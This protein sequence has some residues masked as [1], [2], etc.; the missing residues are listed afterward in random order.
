VPPSS[1]KGFA[2]LSQA[3]SRTARPIERHL[4]I[5]AVLVLAL[6][7]RLWRL[8]RNGYGTEYYAAGV[9]SMLE[10]WH[11]FL[12]NAFDPAGFV[13]VDKPPVALWIQAASARLLG[14]SGFS[15]ILPQVLEGVGSILILYHLVRRRFGDRAGLLAALFLAMTPISV[16]VDRTNNTDGCLVFVLLLSGWAMSLAVERGSGRWLAAALTLVGVGFNVKMLA[17]CVVLPGFAAV[18]LYGAPITLGRRILHLAG[19]GVIF[20]GIALSW[21]VAYDLAAPDTRPYVDSTTDNSMLELAIGHNGVQR[22]VPR[23]FRAGRAAASPAAGSA[24]ADPAGATAA[25]ANQ[26]RAAGALGEF[27]RVDNP[28]IGPLRLFDRHLA[29]QMLWLLPLGLVGFAVTLRRAGLRRPLR[30]E[31]A[32]LL[33]WGGWALT[34]SIVFSVAGGIFHAY[35][36]VTMAPPMAALAGVGVVELRRRGGRAAWLLPVTLTLTAAWQVYLEAPY[37]GG[38]DWRVWLFCALIGGTSLGVAALAAASGLRLTETARH[39]AGGAGLAIAL[40]ALLVTPTAWALSTVIGRGAVSAPSASLAL[41]APDGE[42]AELRPRNLGGS[43]PPPAKLL[44]FLTTHQQET[45]YLAATPNA[46]L[47]APLIIATGQPVMAMGGFLGTDPIL[48]P[49]LL[50]GLV[51]GK[52]L[53][54]V[55]LNDPDT[56]DRAFGAQA[57]QKPLTDWI[58]ANGRPVDPIEWRP[59]PAETTPPDQGR[60]RRGGDLG[61][62]ELYDLRPE[63]VS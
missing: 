39:R 33:L 31:A 52:R 5:A 54:Y 50:A 30:P 42:L 60:R 25:Q 44:D 62:S 37:L 8:D 9:R 1:R 14:F 40:V 27:F 23:M 47:A 13:S 56:L 61:R 45:T 12:F 28:P 29:G 32:S 46:R 19:A 6:T 63:P 26:R 49:E 35:Y 36:L 57:V 3:T 2:A 4:G 18:Y 48:T 21:C 7:L 38:W 58:R 34:Y 53:R 41:L 51:A 20:A 43:E 10:S 24:A 15:L 22:F 16:A 55:L 17:A 59:A 11:N